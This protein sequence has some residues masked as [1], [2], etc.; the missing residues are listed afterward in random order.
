MTPPSK[1]SVNLEYRKVVSSSESQLAFSKFPYLFTNKY[2]F[3]GKI[4]VQVFNIKVIYFLSSFEK[5]IQKQSSQNCPYIRIHAGFGLVVHCP[6]FP[7]TFFH[8]KK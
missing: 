1:V 5:K 3:I 6:Q 8:G 4:L 2:Q 7:V